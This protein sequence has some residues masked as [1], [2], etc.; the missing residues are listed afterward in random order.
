MERRSSDRSRELGGTD[1]DGQS[2]SAQQVPQRE[3]RL[4]FSLADCSP[5]AVSVLTGSGV[6]C[7]VGGRMLPP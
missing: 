4:P 5:P 7:L 2:F 6:G 1:S 3:R